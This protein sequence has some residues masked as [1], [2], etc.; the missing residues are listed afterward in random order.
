M[1]ELGDFPKYAL[2]YRP[3]SSIK[4]SKNSAA[5]FSGGTAFAS[6]DVVVI[7]SIVK[8]VGAKIYNI[9]RVRGVENEKKTK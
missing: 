9:N 3:R 6:T 4:T 2:Q 8:S 7:A 5:E 1:H